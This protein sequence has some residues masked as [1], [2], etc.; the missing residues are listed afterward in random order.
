MILVGALENDK[1]VG[2][3]WSFSNVGF[4]AKCGRL[5]ESALLAAADAKLPGERV[6]GMRQSM[7][8]PV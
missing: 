2:W 8:I 1:L 6:M 7:R 5:I 3:E 4:G